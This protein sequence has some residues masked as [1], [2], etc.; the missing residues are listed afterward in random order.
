MDLPELLDVGS[1]G[2]EFLGVF[3]FRGFTFVLALAEEEAKLTEAGYE[4]QDMTWI[5]PEEFDKWK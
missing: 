5:A 3:L 2:F 4:Q 1:G